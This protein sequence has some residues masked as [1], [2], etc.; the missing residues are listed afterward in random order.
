[1]P[2]T[3]TRVSRRTPRRTKPLPHSNVESALR[4]T[5]GFKPVVSTKIPAGE[6]VF[7]RRSIPGL[8]DFVQ[9]LGAAQALRESRPDLRQVTLAGPEVIYEIGLNNPG[10]VVVTQDRQPRQSEFHILAG[11]HCPCGATE[12]QL[13]PVPAANRLE[14]FARFL[15]VAPQIPKLGLIESEKRQAEIW[16]KR[17]T[18]SANPIVLVGRS[19]ETW[20]DFH[21]PFSLFESLSVT[22]PVVMLDHKREIEWQGRR[23]KWPQPNTAGKSLRQIAAIVNQARLVVTPDTGWLHVAGSLRRPIFGLFGSQEPRFRQALYNVPGAWHQGVCPHGQQPC[24][25]RICCDKNEHPPCLQT[26]PFTVAKLI[27]ETLAKL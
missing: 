3:R 21:D 16:C 26:S 9:L 6:S 11:P 25:Y 8:G 17:M 20:K 2:Q 7:I 23:R 18:G 13:G 1:M 12:G 14:I 4:E 10:R 24:W 19:S 27:T 15:Q 5:S 22:H